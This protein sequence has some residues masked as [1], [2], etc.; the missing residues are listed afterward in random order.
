MYT[1]RFI[2]THDVRYASANLMAFQ[3]SMMGIVLAAT[4]TAV[5]A[6]AVVV[7][8][9]VTNQ[10]VPNAGNIKA[11]G[12]GVYWDISCTN[13]TSSIDWGTLDAGGTRSYTVYVKNNGTAAENLSMSTGNWNPVAAASY[14][15]LAWNCTNYTLAHNAVVGAVLTLTVSPTISGITT[16]NFDITITGTEN[17]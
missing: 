3:K 6:T 10:T 2:N 8:L 1:T 11:I 7:G 15:T 9:L 13:R 17:T 4:M 16:F 12:V 14:I 5:I